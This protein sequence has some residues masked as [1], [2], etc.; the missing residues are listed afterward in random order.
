MELLVKH[1][2]LVEGDTLETCKSYV[3]N[4]FEQTSLVHYDR[5]TIEDEILSAND[6]AFKAKLENGL[7]KNKTTLIRFIDEL[8]ASGFK[9]KCDLID[10]NQGYQS[11]ILHIIAHFL[12][13]FIGIDSVFY[14]LIDDSHWLSDET[15]DKIEQQPDRFRLLSLKC[16]SL[17][18]KEATLLHT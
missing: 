2:I 16:Y 14:N 12:D 3:L 6:P 17:T 1:I 13:G 5:I 18:P 15:R 9:K 8:G 4:F 10:L 11:K 7:K